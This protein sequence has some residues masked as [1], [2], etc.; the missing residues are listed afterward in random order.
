MVLGEVTVGQISIW[1]KSMC[2]CVAD[3]GQSCKAIIFLMGKRDS[4]PFP[5][6]P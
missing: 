2:V 4:H 6:M 3:R 1:Q 5:T